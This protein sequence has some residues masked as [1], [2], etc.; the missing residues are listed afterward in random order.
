MDLQTNKRSTM[1]GAIIYTVF[2]ILA[3]LLLILIPTD[4]L[5][6]L[7]FVIMGIVTVISSLPGLIRGLTTIHTKAGI[8][9]LILS[10][11]SAVLGILMIFWHE[12]VLLI[13]VGIYMILLP[14][15]DILLAKEHF[16]QF[17]AELPKLII[18]A[19][20]ILLGPAGTL[21]ILFDIAG[22]VVIVLNVVY[23]ITVALTL[24]K[25]RDTPGTRV[26]VDQ[27]GNGTIDA[28]YV[29]TTGDGK[30]DAKIKYKNQK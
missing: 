5:L 6:W 28:V 14:I 18:G 11:L 21:D 7:V 30:V 29:D 17:K 13:V 20:L 25:H 10:V 4:F 26:F 23:L 15:L 24:R 16:A 8:L 1:A 2:G 9:T 19:V 3:G 27:D 12:D 22:V